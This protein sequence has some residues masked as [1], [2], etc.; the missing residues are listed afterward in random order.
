[1]THVLEAREVHKSFRQGPEE[2]HVLEGV[3]LSIARAERV[4]I[5]GASG[6]GKTTLLQ[7]LGGLDRPSTGA[8]LVDGRDIHAL[9]EHE[10]GDAAQPRPGLRLP[11]P[12]PAAGVLRAGERGH[13]AAGA[14]RAG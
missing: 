14:A 6:S 9:S 10:R 8:V 7:I 1:M 4:A 2:L 11:V 5:V 12:P 13:A 3:Q